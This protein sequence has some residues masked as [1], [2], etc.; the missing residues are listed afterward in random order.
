MKISEPRILC[1]FSAPLVGPDNK[2]LAALDVEKERKTIVREL[3]AC[4][5]KMAIRVGFATIDEIARGIS[6]G[7][8]ILHL[9]GHGHEDFLLFEDGK[10]GSQ[11]VKGEYLKRLIGT[12]GPFELAIVSA[13]HSEKIAEM[14]AEAGV[15]HVVAIRCDVP[16]LDSA[17]IVFIGQFYRNLFR[18]ES[19]Q[20][21]FEMAKLLVEGD[22]ELAKI[23]PT[24]EFMAGIE[25]EPFVPEEEKFVLLPKEDT[26]QPSFHLYTLVE[27]EIEQG[28]LSIEQVT[29][30]RSNI[31]TRPKSFTGR[32]LEMYSLVNALLANRIVTITGAGGIGKTALGREVA[33]WFHSRG[34]FPD[35]AFCIDLRQ[36]ESSEEIIAMLAA[37][38]EAK[39]SETKDIVEYLRERHCLLLLD[40]L[41]E[42]L[43]KDEE[44]VQE[45]IN[46]ILKFAPN[47]RLLITSQQE[48]GGNLHE[49]EH[50]YR[51]RT[52]EHKYAELIFRAM[53]KREM[54]REEMKSTEFS[55]LLEQLG[56][57]P[58]SIVLMAGQLGPG[59][60]IEDLVERIERQKE[61][62]IEVRSITERDPEHGRSLVASLSSTYENLTEDGKRA[63]GV[64]S[65]M[66]AGAQEFTI[67]QLLGD[68]G[69]EYALELHDASLVEITIYQRIVLIPPV[70]LF[71][72]SVL[73]EDVEEEFGPRILELMASYA[74]QFY[75][76]MGAADAKMYRG[77]FALEEPNL[78]FAVELT[79]HP[80]KSKEE[81]SALGFLATYLLELYI[82]NDRIKEGR[83]IGERLRDKL[84][85]L[86]DKSGQANTLQA[87]GDLS[88]RTADLKEA[89]EKYDKA[90]EIFE[91]IDEKMGQANTLKAL[92]EW[93]ALKGDLESAESRIEEASGIYGEINEIEGEAE[94][95]M[96]RAL[97]LIKRGAEGEA[98]EELRKC[99]KIREKVY[100]HGGAA[101]SLIF[102]AEHLRAGGFNEG[103]KICLEYAEE[104]ASKAR[105]KSLQEKIEKRQK[106]GD[107]G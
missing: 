9:S 51:L 58:L 68:K 55:G 3:S 53:A 8:N 43:W 39:L 48:V 103:A 36:A 42:V 50:N 18:G 24:L 87:L 69:W 41:E 29:P 44:G 77:Y 94:V 107:G 12:G 19:V 25:G 26:S 4:N 61:R 11:P 97:V 100:G 16:I 104:F 47:I 17:A 99:S 56:G 20:K 81:T 82:H 40:N 79:C 96:T 73:R 7:F 102:Y 1:L 80:A 30:A 106:E 6:D 62:A 27:G 64:L 67:K 88:V 83:Q 71:A 31:P 92:G 72:K 74:S 90:L 95:N 28:T 76:H 33:R 86:G 14:I 46:A 75:E 37:S 84:E 66:P 34:H 89:K 63:L 23:K 98:R 57:H 60:R 85:R 13:C 91:K 65:M 38:L 101:V 59:T 45:L 5:R 105:D 78:R 52:V 21:A 70:L 35:G 10:G 15:H 49:G 54:T 2:P 93:S 32:S 22:S